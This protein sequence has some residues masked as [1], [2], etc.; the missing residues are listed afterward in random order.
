ML[1]C[2]AKSK[3]T[4]HISGT[5]CTEKQS[6]S[7]LI[8]KVFAIDSGGWE[9]RNAPQPHVRP[10]SLRCGEI[11]DNA[12]HARAVCTVNVFDFAVCLLLPTPPLGGLFVLA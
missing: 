12:A 10:G 5:N 3:T 2:A 7:P 11:K 4:I 9:C 6:F 8:R 1:L